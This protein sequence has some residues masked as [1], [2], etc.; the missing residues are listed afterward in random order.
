MKQGMRLED[1]E[2]I[3][4]NFPPGYR[5]EAWSIDDIM[6]DLKEGKEVDL[7]AGDWS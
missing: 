5:Y 6:S 3:P 4:A 1:D 7:G 2:R